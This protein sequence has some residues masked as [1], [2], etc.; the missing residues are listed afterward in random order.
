MRTAP[1]PGST[2]TTKISLR[3]RT[4]TRISAFNRK[5]PSSYLDDW[6]TMRTRTLNI[7]VL[8]VAAAPLWG[9]VEPSA[10][11]GSGQTS[12]D[13]YMSMP[14]TVSGGFYPTEV[15]SE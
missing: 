8:L 13:S 7:L 6:K 1:R 5:T 4:W 9:Q 15:G 2:S 3:E 10:E 12:D 11:G 14:A